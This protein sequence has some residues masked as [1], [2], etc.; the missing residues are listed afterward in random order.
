[1]STVADLRGR[2]AFVT[3]GGRGVGRACAVELARRGA[4]VAVAARTADQVEEV[5]AQI[6][7]QGGQAV[8]CPCDVADRAQV[9]AA[10]RKARKALGPVTV[11]VAAAGVARGAP[12]LDTTEVDWELHLRVNAT[13]VFHA[14]QLVL[15]DMLEVGWG[16]IVAV[17]SV[18]AKAAFRGA[19]AYTASK[20]A[21]L[22]LVRSLALEYAPRGITANAVCPG[23]LDTDMTRG[24]V[25]HLATRWGR[26]PQEVRR[27]LEQA[28]PQRRLFTA[29]EVA[30]L[31]A[32][33]CTDEARGI[34]GQ[35]LV[36]DGGR[37]LS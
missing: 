8:A 25:A 1:M 23:Y 32:F 30:S 22:G 19:A 11:L 18:A 37:L 13:G 33:L 14:A 6:A 12:F 7:A 21:L 3:G 31:V 24:N 9:E 5:A 4:A 34:N 10:V 29:E 15:P 35:G 2:V 28:S 17:A 20:H 36:L 26:P 16:R 27:V